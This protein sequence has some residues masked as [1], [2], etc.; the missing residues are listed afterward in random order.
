M[1]NDPTCPYPD[2]YLASRI[3]PDGRIL[4]LMP[5]LQGRARLTIGTNWFDYET[6]W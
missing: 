3:L 4:T 5:L 6:G 1:T 2:Y